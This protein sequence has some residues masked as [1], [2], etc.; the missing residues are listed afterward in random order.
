MNRSKYSV[1]QNDDIFQKFSVIPLHSL[2]NGKCTCGKNDCTKPG[3]HPCIP[4]WR[5]YQRRRPTRDEVTQWRGK[6]PGCNWAVVTGEVSGVVVLDMDGPTGEASLKGKTMPPTRMVRTGKGRHIY[7]Q[8]PGFPVECRT[9]ILPGVDIRGD[10]GYVVAPGSVHASGKKYEWVDGLSP[11]DMP[12]PAEA[13]AWL[14]ELLKR[15][16]GNSSS[17]ID[18]VRV[19]AGVPEGQRDVTLFRYAC[20]L[21]TQ[22]L[23]REEALRL[24]LEAAR[25]CTPPFPEREARLKVEQA[26]KYPEGGGNPKGVSATDLLKMDFPDPAWCVPGLLPEGLTILGGKPKIGK[27][28]L[29]LNLA[30]AVANGG[31]ALGVDVEPGPVMYLALEDTPRRLKSRLLSVLNGS[32]A[33]RWLH[34]YTSWPKLDENGLT[35]LE[36]EILRR[37]ARLIIIDTFQRIRP[38]QR[39]NGNIYGLDYEDVARLKQVADRCGVAMLLVHHLKKAS[40]IDPVDMLSGSTGLSGAADAIWVLTRER[41]QADAILYVTGRD[42]EEKELALSFDPATTTWNIMGTAQE[43][44][45]SR[46]RRE[47]LE[48]LRE[49][50]EPLG[51]KEIADLTGKPYA[52]IKKLVYVMAKSGE[53]KLVTRGRYIIGNFGNYGNFGNHG[54]FGNFQEKLPGSAESYRKVTGAENPQSLQPQGFTGKSY[55]SNQS[56]QQ[57]ENETVTFEGWE[58]IDSIDI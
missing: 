16:G 47:I 55:R 2:K 6:Y 53:L 57:R 9:G 42:L 19:L 36:A 24:V 14:V 44:R 37:E 30:V 35:L 38:V 1:P 56:N 7:F 28:W 31:K 20:R 51:P 22:G 15:P 17:K 32:P 21:R 18:P 12:E 10:G 46:E 27:S 52:N 49:A 48:V 29:A 25:N 11:A 54:N 41:G 45:M 5:V 13:P 58:D 39:G 33:P 40:E 23:T 34:F 43:Y 3:K 8:W 4:E 50:E 26:W